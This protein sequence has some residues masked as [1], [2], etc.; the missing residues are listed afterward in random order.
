[1]RT[2][3][4]SFELSFSFRCFIVEMMSGIQGIRGSGINMQGPTKIR[5]VFGNGRISIE[6]GGS[7]LILTSS[8][9]SPIFVADDVFIS[10]F[11]YSNDAQAES[12][13]HTTNG[14]NDGAPL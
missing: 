3:K 10:P 7:I 4:I 13:I 5:S 8:R 14:I 2:T 9:Y 1:M 12:K 11:L 6:S